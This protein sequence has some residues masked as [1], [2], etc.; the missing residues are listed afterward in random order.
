MNGYMQRP[1]AP[2]LMR[3]AQPSGGL[4]MGGGGNTAGLE[5]LHQIKQQTDAMI[6]ERQK[7]EQSSNHY[8]RAH[9]HVCVHHGSLV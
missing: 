4:L 8:V 5:G 6:A 9:R 2:G 3:Q 1:A 7:A